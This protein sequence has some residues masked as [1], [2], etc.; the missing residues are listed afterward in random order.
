MS[1]PSASCPNCG[2]KIDFR[3]SSAVQ[4]TC[5]FCKSI[6]VRH[7]VDLRKVG[8]VGDLPSDQTPIQLGT[9]GRHGRRGFTVVGRIMY[10]YER[11]TWNEW[12]I[13]LDDQTSEWLSDAVAEYAVSRAVQAPDTP[14][15]KDVSVGRSYAWEKR[16]YKVTS[17]TTAHYRGVEG[18]LPFE[19]WDKHD[20]LFADLS[21][22]DGHFATLDYSDQPP[23]LYLGEY[24][25]F[26]DL[27]MDNLRAIAGW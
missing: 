1:G 27:R 10:E 5:A 19:Y 17:L 21:T 24:V 7:D 2:A 12:H 22:D 26:D 15:A 3:W 8:E 20:V 18:E 13:R 6:L 9:T 11:G 4:T 25:E 14:A 16:I 23:T